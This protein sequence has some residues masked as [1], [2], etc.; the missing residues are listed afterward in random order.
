MR[1]HGP[2]RMTFSR[3][4]LRELPPT[5]RLAAPITAGQVGQM[6]MGVADTIMIGRVG[7]L[8]LAACAFANNILIVV[9]VAGYGVLTVV[10]IRVSHAHGAG[11]SPVMAQALHAGIGLSVFGGI[12]AALFLHLAYPAFDY[13]GQA[14]GV[15]DEARSY[16]VIVGWSLIAAWLTSTVRNYLDAQSRPWP[17]FGSCLVGS[18]LTW[19]LI[20]FSSTAVLGSRPWG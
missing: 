14:A 3:A 5:L 17:A 4:T 18:S 9:A 20:G 8:A 12:V 16:T 6:L 1:Q 11:T 10:S 19:C 15:V 13:L 2:L 7:T